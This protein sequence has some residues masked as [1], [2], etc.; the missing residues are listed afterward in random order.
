MQDRST[1]F[2]F[3]PIDV[4]LRR[5]QRY[6]AKFISFSGTLVAYGTGVSGSATGANIIVK[7]PVTMRA[8]PTVS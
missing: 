1:D 6:Y 8:S 3:L 2:E 7:Y 5:C 4:S